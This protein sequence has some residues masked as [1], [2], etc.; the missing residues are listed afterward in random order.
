MSGCRW[1]HVVGYDVLD[2]YV[3][4][5]VKI[6]D[7]VDDSEPVGF[8]SANGVAEDVSNDPNVDVNNEIGQ[9]G[10]DKDQFVSEGNFKDNEFQFIEEFDE[11]EMDWIKVLF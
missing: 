3:E 7:I 2:I 8:K 11:S 4:H 6:H 9:E 1:F 5:D 10:L